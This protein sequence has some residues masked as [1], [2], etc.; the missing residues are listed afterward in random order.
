MKDIIKARD[1]L[2]LT[3]ILVGVLFWVFESAVH[4]FLFQDGP[5]LQQIY[6]PGRHEAWMRSIVVGMFIGFGIYAHRIIIALTRAEEAVR[7][8]WVKVGK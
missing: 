7:R 8:D 5:F 4:T 6:S 3:G 1:R 2:I